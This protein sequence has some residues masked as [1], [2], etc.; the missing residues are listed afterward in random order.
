MI[1]YE[2]LRELMRNRTEEL[3]RHFFPNGR[4]EGQE[5]KLADV[6][7]APGNSLGIQ[8]TGPKAG[9]FHD[10]ATGQ[11]GDLLKLICL[12]RNCG[13]PQAVGQIERAFGINLRSGNQAYSVA[14][15]LEDPPR[16]PAAEKKRED[17]KLWDVEMATDADIERLS[18][19][20]R[21]SIEGLRLAADR[22]LLFSYQDPHQGRCWLVSDGS[23]RSASYRRL[24]GKRFHF[25]EATEDK[26]EGPKSKSW[27]GSEKNWPIGIAQADGFHSIALCEGEPDFL[28]AFALAHAGA[29][30]SLVAPICMG[31]AAC[32]IHED[33]L[34][35][36]RGKRVRIFGH[37]DEAGQKA[38]QKWTEQLESVQ[39][40]VD[41]F[42]FSGLLR[43]DGSA[44]KDLNDF[45]GADHKRSG[46]A[47]EVTTGAFDFALERRD[48]NAARTV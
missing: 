27:K 12:S 15:S 22:R 42:D 18:S 48:L 21:I 5:W 30:E 28:A 9:L 14:R 31:S 3:C 20:R 4:K 2:L 26:K 40:E 16:R 11:S 10:R 24:D 33:A 23:R 6:S 32:S 47:I 39:A 8:L 38:V 35:M 45:I 37:A 17:L 43:A 7:G 36:F 25:R 44:V 46:C 41:A 29:V 1:N 13:L 34:P 19:L